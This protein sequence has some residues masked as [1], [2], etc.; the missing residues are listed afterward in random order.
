MATLLDFE[1]YLPEVP[2]NAAVVIELRQGVNSKNYYVKL[3]YKNN[4]INQPHEFKSVKMK[5]CAKLCP[6]GDFLSLTSKRI[7]SDY[8]AACNSTSLNVE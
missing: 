3:L 2:Y 1:S 5:N 6:L 4:L 7:I 8:A